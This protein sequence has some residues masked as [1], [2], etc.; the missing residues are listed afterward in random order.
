[1]GRPALDPGVSTAG[2]PEVQGPGPAPGTR[3]EVSDGKPDG[4]ELRQGDN[5]SELGGREDRGG[6]DEQEAGEPG[7]ADLERA[8]LREDHVTEVGEVIEVWRPLLRNV[9]SAVRQG[10]IERAANVIHEKEY[11]GFTEEAIE[12]R[13]L[14]RPPTHPHPFQ[15]STGNLTTSSDPVYYRVCHDV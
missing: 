7:T 2:K 8:G 11:R 12:S 6:R 15:I 9:V 5:V 13:L 10:D 1:M 3:G 14:N 4:G